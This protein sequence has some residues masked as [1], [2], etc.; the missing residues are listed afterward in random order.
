MRYRKPHSINWV[1]FL[2]IGLAGLLVYAV[3]YTWPV[4]AAHSRVRGILLDHVPPLYKANLMPDDV[5]RGMM[6]EIKRS[7]ADQIKKAGMN[8][9]A[10]KIILRRSPKFVELEAR[11]KAYARFPF[12]EKTFEIN[13][14]PKVVSDAA[15]VDW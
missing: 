6:E 5:S 14:S 8:D 4:Y 15:R 13:L 1:T 3:V 12:P 11:F 9:K 2:L 10:V 7:I